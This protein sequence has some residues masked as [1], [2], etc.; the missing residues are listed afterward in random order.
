MK[1]SNA[2]RQICLA[3]AL[4]II[5]SHAASAP[6]LEPCDRLMDDY[7][8]RVERL[9]RDAWPEGMQLLVIMYIPPAERGLGLTPDK[10]GFKLV[11]LELD[12]SLWYSS[13]RDVKGSVPKRQVQDFS[14]TRARIAKLSFP[15]SDRLAVALLDAFERSA[16]TAK[17]DVS[18]DIIADGYTYEILLPERSCVRLRDPPPASDAGAIADLLRFLEQAALSWQPRKR[19]AF[20]AE[21]EERIAMIRRD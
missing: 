16:A 2:P 13:W 20:E 17:P 3:A 5:W 11:R 21:V 19:E 4:T 10:D 7:Y 18:D 8:R 12:P 9:M 6:H 1:A 14:G 15:I